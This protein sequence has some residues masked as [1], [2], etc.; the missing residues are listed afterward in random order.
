MSIIRDLEAQI[1]TD[2]ASIPALAG[3]RVIAT[4]RELDD[5]TQPTA[6]IRG[7]SIARTP[8]APL[9]HRTR[10]LLLTLISPHLDLDRASD[11]LEPLTWAALDYLDPRYQ[12]DDATD[13]GY[14]KRF[15]NDIP[16]TVIASK[17]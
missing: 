17:E 1:K 6:L 12:H 11:Q 13:V 7:K 14:G 4:E 3:V 15:A 2:W 5:I 16:F 8:G 10:G 9:S